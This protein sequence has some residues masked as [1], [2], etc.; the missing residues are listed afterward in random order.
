MPF[1]CNCS[2]LPSVTVKT[3]T[4]LQRG[5][6][7]RKIGHCAQI[8]Q[9]KQV[10][11]EVLSRVA[12]YWQSQVLSKATSINANGFFAGYVSGEARWP[13]SRYRCAEFQEPLRL[14]LQWT[15]FTSCWPN[16]WW[17]QRLG[18]FALIRSRL[19][20][21]KKLQAWLGSLRCMTQG[22]N[23]FAWVEERWNFP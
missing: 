7:F 23:R 15:D 6:S 5:I 16:P 2:K 17:S 20:A 8:L 13:S 21:G 9:S 19:D 4:D 12:Q 11:F 3:S 10:A 14:C 1:N 22:W 18:S